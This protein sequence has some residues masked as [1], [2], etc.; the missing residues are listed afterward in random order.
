MVPTTSLGNNTSTSDPAHIVKRAPRLLGRWA[1]VTRG[2]SFVTSVDTMWT[3]L[4]QTTTM[5]VRQ[6]GNSGYCEGN[7]V[8]RYHRDI[9]RGAA[10]RPGTSHGP[11]TLHDLH[12]NKPKQRF[13]LFGDTSD[14]EYAMFYCEAPGN[15]LTIID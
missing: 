13:Q 11:S 4:Y 7:G 8:T 6:A 3:Y 12:F 5:R 10:G 2:R 14:L 9:I 15:S 1:G